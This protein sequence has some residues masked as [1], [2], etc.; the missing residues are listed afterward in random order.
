MDKIKIA[1]AKGRLAE[2]AIGIM[3]DAGIEFPDY[4]KKSR[5][6]IFEDK[7]G[8]IRI[9]FVKPWDVPVYVDKG[10]ADMGMVGKDVLIENQVDVYEVADLGIGKCR[11]CVAGYGNQQFDKKKKL[12]IG[13]KFS[14]AAKEY[15]NKR[16]IPTEVIKLNGSVE[17]A[18][19]MGL[20]D[21]IV[22]IVETGSTLRENGLVILEEMFEISARLIVNKVSLKTKS[23]EID[24][25][26]EKIE[27]VIGKR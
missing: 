10:A 26:I 13:T 11:L 12:K 7:T 14:V 24:K 27:N 6:L 5:K 23:G 19:L 9:I 8:R 2:E 16:G 18:P 3:E 20:S 4:N 21:V 1:L 25:L 15:F 17:L 22:D